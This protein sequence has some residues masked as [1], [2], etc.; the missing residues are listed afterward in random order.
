MSKLSI[1]ILV[2]FR[3]N[4]NAEEARDVSRLLVLLERVSLVGSRLDDRR[5]KLVS[6]GSFSCKSFHRF[7]I[8]DLSKQIF[9]LANLSA[10][11][12]EGQGFRLVGATC[13]PYKV[14]DRVSIMV[15]RIVKLL[16]FYGRSYL[17]RL[18]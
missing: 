8:D 18:G 15:L 13:V 9:C 16:F 6:S 4:L 3:R 14:R 10:S 7:L 5:W 1:R 2:D 12:T 11:S 17:G